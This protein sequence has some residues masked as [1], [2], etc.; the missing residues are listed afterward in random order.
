MQ[1]I[2]SLWKTSTGGKFIIIAGSI[3]ALCLSCVG[4]SLLVP[5]SALATP[6]TDPN[7]I[8]TTIAQTA[9]AI[10]AAS[11]PTSTTE[12]TIVAAP[13]FTD[14]SATDY[15][16]VAAARFQTLEAAINEM[17][18]LHQALIADMTLA[19]NSDWY[20]TMNATLFRV[21]AGARELAAMRNVP[22]EYAL[23]H[24]VLLQ[25]ESETKLAS[26][27]Y[28]QAL[29]HQDVDALNRATQHLSNMI[30]YVNQAHAELN[31]A[32]VTATP[33]PTFTALATFT[34]IVVI[35]PTS[36][37]SNCLA[38]YPDF[39]IQASPRIPCDDLPKNFTVLPPDPLGYDR[40]NDGVGCEN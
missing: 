16:Q 22:P 8:N 14:I 32:A 29:D 33:V 15:P 34:P 28:T 11:T 24:Q 21:E 40:D 25:L 27:E 4:V 2:A 3:I 1:R 37:P 13:T 6:T 12:P 19:A 31:V 20:A 30:T 39:C 26:P 7:V 18:P 17:V 36:A 35:Q 38:A 9:L 5:E 23:F 10:I